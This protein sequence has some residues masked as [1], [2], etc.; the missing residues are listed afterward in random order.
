LHG[1]CK[2]TGQQLA[3]KGI[4]VNGVVPGLD[5]F[6]VSGGATPGGPA[7]LHWPVGADQKVK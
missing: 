6:A 2:I 4:R 7:N 1:I 3:L 5:A